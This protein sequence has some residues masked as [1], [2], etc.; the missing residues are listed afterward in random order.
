M[1]KHMTYLERFNQKVE[2][3]DTC[4]LW[5]GAKNSKGYGA[6]S[7]NGKG[8]SDHRLSYILHKGEIP[9]GLI[10][11]HTCDNPQCVNPDHLWAG[12][13]SDNMKDMF[14]KDR[15]GSTNRQQTHCRK[16]HEFTPENIFSRTNADGTKQRICRECIRISR[17]TN[18]ANPEKRE[19]I[20]AYDREYQKRYRQQKQSHA[21]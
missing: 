7:Y 9:D 4:W 18:R 19:K 8:T 3:T 15:H 14:K 1:A 2:K 5:T 16:G 20:L 21:R 13:S 12:T 17:K 10:I 6:M 11:C